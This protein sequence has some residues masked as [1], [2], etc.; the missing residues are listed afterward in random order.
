MSG[1]NPIVQLPYGNYVGV[2]IYGR[3]GCGGYYMV[4][5]WLYGPE[6]RIG[7]WMDA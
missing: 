4:E 7:R 1:W 3:H 5:A 2:R 6:G